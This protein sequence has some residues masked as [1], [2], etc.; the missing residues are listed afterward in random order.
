MAALLLIASYLSVHVN[1][2]KI[3]MF[4]FFG[5]AYPFI[6][7]INLLF[8]LFWLYRWKKLFLLSLAIVI[9]G[10][11]Y[12]EKYFQIPLSKEK[13]NLSYIDDSQEDTLVKLTS[14]NVRLFNLYNWADDES[15]ESGIFKFIRANDP[16]ILCLQEFFV[17]EQGEYTSNEVKQ[18]LGFLKYSH[19][20]Y[21]V[22][23]SNNAKYGMATFSKYPIVQKGFIQYEDSHNLS[24]FTDVIIKEDTVRIFNNHLQSIR[25]KQKNYDFLR[26]LDLKYD[27]TQM[28][29]IRDISNKIRDAF[30]KRA[31]QVD[32]I[33]ERIQ[34]SPYPVVVC[35]DFND[36]P[37]S[38]TYREMKNNLTDA[39][40][41]A[42]VWAG[43]TYNG[44]LP[45]FRIDYIFH[46]PSIVSY[47]FRKEKIRF[48]DHY[49]IYCYLDVK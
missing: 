30:I 25:F 44:T 1:P 22:I 41:N 43:N 47:H 32:L 29:E 18:E 33:K 28:D 5:L 15:A 42:G 23:A 38:Y 39:Y 19:T 31:E 2:G 20:H 37:V 35:G 13:K 36:T 34:Q 17:D 16:D 6:L 8:I 4:S 45:S 7:I 27:E 48:S 26:H 24:I 3:W 10:W 11:N 40:V 12:I 9:L 21:T 46:D 14:Y 49:P